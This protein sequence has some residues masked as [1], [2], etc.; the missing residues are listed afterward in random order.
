MLFFS[1]KTN[2]KRDIY[3]IPISR[4]SD[5]KNVKWHGW[6]EGGVGNVLRIVNLKKKKNGISQLTTFY[7]FVNRYHIHIHPSFNSPI[8]PAIV[9][10]KECCKK[11]KSPYHSSSLSYP[12]LI[13]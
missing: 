10:E 2:P 9:L 6:P 5:E 4:L 3:K 8:N 12:F 1:F 7:C 13:R 11:K